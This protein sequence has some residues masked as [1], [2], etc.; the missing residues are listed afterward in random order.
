MTQHGHEEH[1]TEPSG[2]MVFAAAVALFVIV[3]IL[4]FLGGVMLAASPLLF[5]FYVGLLVLT[6]G[7]AYHYWRDR[8]Y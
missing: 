1:G 7:G 4:L 6:F 8:R 2:S 3:S 5:I